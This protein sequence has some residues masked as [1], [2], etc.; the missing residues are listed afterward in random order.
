MIGVRVGLFHW[1][2]LDW[3]ESFDSGRIQEKSRPVM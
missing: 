1:T 3:S 2:D